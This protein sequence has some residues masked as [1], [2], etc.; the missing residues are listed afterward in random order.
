MLLY[1]D[2][3]SGQALLNLL[4]TEAAFGTLSRSL[5]PKINEIEIGL[6]DYE[7]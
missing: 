7:N 3:E 5:K 2:K 6:L 1:L 4:N